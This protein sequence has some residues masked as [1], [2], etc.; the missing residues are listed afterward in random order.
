VG[1]KKGLGA[2][3]VTAN[4]LDLETAA[5]QRDQEQAKAVKEAFSHTAVGKPYDQPMCVPAAF[6]AIFKVFSC[7]V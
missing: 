6:L 5:L 1:G 3:K 7:S 4:F 2:Q